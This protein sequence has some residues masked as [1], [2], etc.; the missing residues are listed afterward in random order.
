MA[1][2]LHKHAGLRS[3]GSLTTEPIPMKRMLSRIAWLVPAAGAAMLSLAFSSGAAM[4]APSACDAVAG[5]LIVNCGFESGNFSGWTVTGNNQA[6]GVAG[7][8]GPGGYAP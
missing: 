6:T 2:R 4:A 5:N 1:R 3:A 7:N 8:G